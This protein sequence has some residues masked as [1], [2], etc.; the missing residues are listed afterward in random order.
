MSTMRFRWSHRGYV[1][2]GLITVALVGAYGF[3]GEQFDGVVVRIIDGDTIA[4]HGAPNEIIIRIWGVDS[5]EMDQPYG[6]G[7]KMA[8]GELCMGHMVHVEVKDVDRYKRRVG[9]VT[10]PDGRDLG[11]ELVRQG[12]AWW[13][14]KYA[15]RD[16]Q[17]K[18]FE[19]T[20]R[21]GE[22]GLWDHPPCIDPSIWRKRQ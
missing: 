16:R 12:A 5:P 15:P 19:A 11:E 9:R 13:A 22:V 8:M 10:L 21:A 20:A 3:R 14:R 6:V 4:M 2:I 18:K 1:A 17:L 7:A